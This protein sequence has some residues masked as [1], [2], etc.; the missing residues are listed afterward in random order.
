M[1]R[2]VLVTAPTAMPV[3][4]TEAKAHLRV[5]SSDED[6]LI[7]ALI[8]SATAYLDGWTGILGRC[9]MQQIWRQHYDCFD[10]E[11]VAL[12][13]ARWDRSH[14]LHHRCGL[15]LPLVPVISVTPNPDN[16]SDPLGVHYLDTAGVQQ[17]VA[18][19][20][21]ELLV[22]DL[23]A[24]VRFKIDFVFPMTQLQGPVV[25]ITYSAGYLTEQP[26][27]PAENVELLPVPIKQA[28]LLMIGHWYA[29]REAVAVGSISAASLPLA[30][31]AL[32]APYRRARF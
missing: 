16:P 20:N 15:R 23:G 31:E 2:P 32:L 25:S 3:S 6:A 27:S 8:A 1:Y 5:T 12:R 10:G 17:S 30:V 28:M 24:F 29:N 26:A 11:I 4:L 19:E 7:T 13:A 21:Y 22:D 14:R 18:S 9:L